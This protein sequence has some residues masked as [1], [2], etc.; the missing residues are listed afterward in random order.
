MKDLKPHIRDI[1][2]F[3]VQGILFRDITP[4]LADGAAFA[5]AVRQLTAEAPPQ[6]TH[7]AA[8]DARG[9]IFASAVAVALGVGMV[10]VRKPGK[11]PAE[12]LSVDYELEYGSNTLTMHKD[13][14]RAGDVVYLIDDLIATGGTLAAA[15]SLVTASGATL[16]KIACL[17]ELSELN[18]REKLP[19]VPFVTM[20]KY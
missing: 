3:P 18:G 7:I 16:G 10:P 19:P 11:L 12:V 17:I 8:V 14:L 4:L 20:V 13:A 9:F 15:A 1:M 2:D 6:T 5:E